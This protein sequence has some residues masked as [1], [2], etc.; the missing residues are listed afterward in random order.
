MQQEIDLLA[1]RLKSISMQRLNYKQTKLN[2]MKSWIETQD[3]RRTSALS[4]F[5]EK[6]PTATVANCC[7]CC[8]IDVTAFE[9]EKEQFQ[10]LPYEGWRK[11]WQGLL[12][13]QSKKA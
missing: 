6:P 1:D 12:H 5:G 11:E 4:I 10:S 9:S 8:G 7:D 2:E 3:C 13:L